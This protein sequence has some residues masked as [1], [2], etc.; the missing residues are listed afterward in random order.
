M[1]LMDWLRQRLSG[2]EKAELVVDSE[3]GVLA[4]LNLKQVLDAHTA[5]KTKLKNELDGKGKESLDVSIIAQDNQCEL[6]RW[7]HG[8]G[9]LSFS[10]YP[11]YHSA[12]TAHSEFHFCAAEVLMQYQAGAPA[13]AEA[14]LKG[15][16][17]Q[18]SNKNQLELVRLFVAARKPT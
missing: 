18:A 9:K 12:C 13:A 17:R 1:A 6:G 2:N 15:K 7:L 5:W 8:P 4:G 10:H 11:E 3:E 14:L 16:F